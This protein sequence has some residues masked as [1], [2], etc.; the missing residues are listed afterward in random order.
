MPRAGRR[1]T[2][3]HR[4]VGYLRV[5]TDEQSLGPAAQHD[6]LVRWCRAHQIE[7]VDVHQDLGV[8]GG[9]PLDKR[10]GLLGALDAMKRQDAGVLL[11]A[12]RDRLARDVV[13]AAMVERLVERGGGRV[14]AA[15]GTGNGDTPEAALLRGVVDVFAAYER[16]LIKART[17]AGLAVKKSRAERVGQVPYGYRLAEDR[18]HLEPDPVEQKVIATI[19]SLRAQGRSGRQIVDALQAVGARARGGRW[20]RTTISRI[21]QRHT[22][23]Q[24][25]LRAS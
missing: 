6:A 11:V 19:L 4:A 7:L 21:L 18:H 3:L 16:Q 20:H 2:N 14:Q 13:V 25:Q 23:D 1:R 8:S 22:A 15:D 12:K 5:S 24:E 10:P 9:A 17:K